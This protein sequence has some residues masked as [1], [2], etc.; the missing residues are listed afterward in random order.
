MVLPLSEIMPTDGM[1]VGLAVKSFDEELAS[2]GQAAK[3]VGSPLALFMERYS[4]LGIPVVSYETGE[5]E[6]ELRVM[7]GHDHR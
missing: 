4:A 2:V 1:R 3:L 6:Q 5:V 7:E